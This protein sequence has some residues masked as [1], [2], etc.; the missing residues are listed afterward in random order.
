MLFSPALSLAKI[1]YKE[2]LS[3]GLAD[4]GQPPPFQL[5]NNKETTS[6]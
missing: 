6:K 5:D 1:K 3:L 4:E 2:P